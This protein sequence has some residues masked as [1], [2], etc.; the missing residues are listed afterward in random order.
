MKIPAIS[1][2]QMIT[3]AV[4]GVLLYVLLRGFRGAAKDA[5]KAVVGV[6]D[7]AIAGTAI[8]IGEAFGIPET[9]K[10]ACELAIAEGRKWDAS[11]ACPA[12]TFIKSL[13]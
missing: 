5:T 7:G 1:Q 4:G 6:A 10:T 12:G 2:Q 13:F 9:N 8:G 3:V 11:F